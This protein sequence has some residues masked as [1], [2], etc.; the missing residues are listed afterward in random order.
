M[1]SLVIHGIGVA[2]EA[3]SKRLFR[4]A[5]NGGGDVNHTMFW[6][7]MKPNG[8]GKPTGAIAD[9]MRKVFGEYKPVNTL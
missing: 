9:A 3:G 5:R 6:Q 1:R 4:I 7:I 8:G 2:V